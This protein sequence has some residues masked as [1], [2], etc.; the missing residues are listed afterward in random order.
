MK[1]K[2]ALL[3][4]IAL[5]LISALPCSAMATDK[6]LTL[7]SQ[8]NHFSRIPGFEDWSN[9]TLVDNGILFSSDDNIYR[10]FTIESIVSSENIGYVICNDQFEIIEFSR[11]RSPYCDYYEKC[12]DGV[13]NRKILKAFYEPGFHGLISG[14]QI[15][16]IE[17]DDLVNDSFDEVIE[18]ANE[19]DA[20]ILRGSVDKYKVISGVPNYP[21]TASCIPTAIGNILGYWDSHGYPNLMTGSYSAMINEISSLMGVNTA[22]ANIPKAVHQYCHKNGRY[23]NKFTATNISKPQFTQLK[24][25]IDAGRPTLVGF[26][27]GGAYSGAHMTACIGYYYEITSSA[28]YIYVHDGGHHS[29]DYFVQWN[30]TYNDFIGKIVP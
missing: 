8:I 2:M 17:C 10:H 22:N 11:Y 20:S 5:I 9:C 7:E 26:A 28:R 30:G 16:V 19:A 18:T 27:K 15:Q 24:P 23:P 21:Y 6:R 1:K 13:L 29:G 4:T 3:L 12:A 25:E 14:D